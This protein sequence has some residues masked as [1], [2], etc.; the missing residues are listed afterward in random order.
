MIKTIRVSDKGQIAIPQ[1]MREIMGI[2]RGDELVVI[3]IDN[4]IMIEKAEKAEK[5][6]QDDFKDVLKH[7]ENSLKKVWGDKSDDIWNEY[8]KR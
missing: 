2:E 3:Q 6:L 8:L 4:K 1:P 5:R 7:S